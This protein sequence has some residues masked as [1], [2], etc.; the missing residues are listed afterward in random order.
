VANF[1]V[2]STVVSMALTD[3]AIEQARAILAGGR[4]QET[5]DILCASL[6][7]L[8]P[9]ACDLVLVLSYVK[10]KLDAEWEIKLRVAPFHW[11]PGNP[12]RGIA[13]FAKVSTRV[14]AQIPISVIGFGFSLAGCPIRGSETVYLNGQLVDRR[15][16]E[17]TG[18]DGGPNLNLMGGTLRAGDMIQIQYDME[19][20]W[21][22]AVW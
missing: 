6:D 21:P 1:F 19:E 11:I 4:T 2:G 17:I 18:E 10:E 9:L 5:W 7:S 14:T 22:I 20:I 3:R 12:R 8:N 16:Y 13:C 15:D